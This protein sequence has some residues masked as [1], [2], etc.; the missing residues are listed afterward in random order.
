MR[1][2]ILVL[3]AAATL[4]AGCAQLPTVQPWEKGHLARPAMTFE[5]N[6]L[7]S[8]YT[9]HIYTSKESSSGGIGVGGGGCG[10]N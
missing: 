2:P 9:E 7:E 4:A 3:A 8:R 10:C 6:G 1:R 5:S